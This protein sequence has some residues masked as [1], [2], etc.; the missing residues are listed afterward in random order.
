MSRA[1]YKRSGTQS[2]FGV[3]LVILVIG[4]LMVTVS[5]R[6]VSLMEKRD[7]LQSRIDTL[8]AQIAEQEERSEQIEQYDKYTKTRG[9]IEEIAKSR[10]GL[11]YPGEI[12]FKAED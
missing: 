11:V 3:F 2:L 9:Y 4:L 10:L 5:F 8:E 12:I 6:G 1:R 7:A